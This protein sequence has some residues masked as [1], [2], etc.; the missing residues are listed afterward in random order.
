[1][2]TLKPCGWRCR[3]GLSSLG[4]WRGNTGRCPLWSTYKSTGERL[5]TSRAGRRVATFLA[6]VKVPR[7][8]SITVLVTLCPL[9]GLSEP[10]TWPEASTALLS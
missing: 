7:P 4:E 1:M 3:L 6:E 10:R 9:Q 2:N 8:V 5:E